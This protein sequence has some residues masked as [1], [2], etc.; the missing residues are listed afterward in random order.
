[1][2]QIEAGDQAQNIHLDAFNPA[3]LMP[4]VTT[5]LSQARAAIGPAHIKA[6]RKVTPDCVRWQRDAE[7][8]PHEGS[9]Q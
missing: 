9:R 4:A 6:Q 5:H 3:D 8:R 2:T 1:M 7:F